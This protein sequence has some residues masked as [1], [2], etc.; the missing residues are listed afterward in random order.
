MARRRF[1]D[2]K[3]DW[4]HTKRSRKKRS[5]CGPS[6]PWCRS[7]RLHKHEKQMMLAHDRTE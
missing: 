2:R 4:R 1:V 7:N 6:C 5:W 3:K